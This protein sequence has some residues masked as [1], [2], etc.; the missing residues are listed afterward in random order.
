[1]AECDRR[2]NT[3][4]RPDPRTTTV[5]RSRCT[6]ESRNRRSRL[7]G[8][9]A[10]TVWQIAIVRGLRWMN[11]RVSDDPLV[12]VAPFRAAPTSMKQSVSTALNRAVRSYVVCAA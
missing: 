5:S 3:A 11:E 10:L 4:D 7:Y 6:R 1:V 9:F 2:T 12:A 8:S